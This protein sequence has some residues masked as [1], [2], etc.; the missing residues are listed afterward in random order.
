MF[1]SK[2][3]VAILSSLPPCSGTCWNVADAICPYLDSLIFR[4]KIMV[5]FARKTFRKVASDHFS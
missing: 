3:A 4:E 2:R 5:S 1:S